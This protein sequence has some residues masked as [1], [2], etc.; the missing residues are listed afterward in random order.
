MET[1]S[2]E[3]HSYESWDRPRS[4]EE[5]GSFVTSRLAALEELDIGVEL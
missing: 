3:K 5:L 1:L 4:K 2:T